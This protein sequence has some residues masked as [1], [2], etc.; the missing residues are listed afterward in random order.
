[1]AFDKARWMSVNEKR[2]ALHSR[3]TDR[4]DAI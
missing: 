4:K 2:K 1:M 3:K